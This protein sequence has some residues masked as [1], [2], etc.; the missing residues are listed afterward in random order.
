MA[1]SERIETLIIGG[2]Q[3]GLVMSHMLTKR[4]RP[5]LVVERLRIAE[6][7][8]TERW[9][10][11]YFQFPNWSVGLPDFPFPHDDPEGFAGK[12]EIIAYI[13]AYAAFINPPLR[14]GVTVT[15][16]RR[17]PGGKGFISETSEGTIE[18]DNVVVATG[19]Y[20]RPKLPDVAGDTG[21]L[22]QVHASHYANPQQLPPGAVLVVGAGASG[23]QIAEELLRAG[24]RVYLAVG[25][26]RRLPRRYRGRDF[27]WWMQS[28][29]ASELLPADRGPRNF[30]SLVITGAYGGYTVDFRNFAAAGITLTGHFAGARDGVL[31]FADD[32]AENLK[33]GDAVYRGF[34]DMADA[35]VAHAKLAMP[36]EPDA[37]RLPPDPPALR[38]PPR[39]LD[40][41]GDNIGAIIWATGY[42][43]DFGWIDLPVFQANGEPIHRLGIADVS[44]LYFLGLL[45]L[46]GPGS[47]FLSGVGDDASRLADHLVVRGG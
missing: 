40:I 24:R 3:A 45:W 46:S 14:T 27:R 26:H 21:D 28:L 43:L 16:L 36:P 15:S 34:L 18:S 2:G 13:D 42:A 12:D 5:H 32:L 9:D 41:R 31:H 30:L 20:Q 44:G 19:P 11:L 1:G 23:A 38:N 25:Q 47:S 39:Q 35:Y 22:F 4:G 33:A 29:R 6:R 8:R 10:G 37:H 17:G 7:W